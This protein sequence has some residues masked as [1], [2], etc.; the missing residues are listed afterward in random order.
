MNLFN[1][2][3]LYDNR[4]TVQTYSAEMQLHHQ[5]TVPPA[6]IEPA[7]FQS[8]GYDCNAIHFDGKL[9]KSALQLRMVGFIEVYPFSS[10]TTE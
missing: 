2:I 5:T 9:E 10:Y 7:R 1:Q 6:G 3:R 4:V 8:S